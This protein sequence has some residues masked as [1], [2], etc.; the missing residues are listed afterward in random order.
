M[1]LEAFPRVL[2]SLRGAEMVTLQQTECTREEIVPWVAASL[3]IQW[4]GKEAFKPDGLSDT[5]QILETEL[6]QKTSPAVVRL[7]RYASLEALGTSPKEKGATMR[8]LY[9]DGAAA[10]AADEAAAKAA[11]EAAAA[12]DGG[13]TRAQSE[14]GHPR[15]R[16]RT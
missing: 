4:V 11:E 9:L 2:L 6:A 8:L 1:A 15:S 3:G 5:L 14:S 7:R 13:G 10:K 16:S 12:A